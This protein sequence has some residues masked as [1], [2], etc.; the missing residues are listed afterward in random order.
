MERLYG[1]P[2]AD[3]IAMWVADMDF[4]PPNCVQRA[5]EKHGQPMVSTATTAMTRISGRDPLVDGNPPWLD[6]SDRGDLHHARSGRT[7]PRF[8]SMPLPNPVM[9]SC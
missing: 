6:G 2:A 7:A 9:A 5:I 3:G 4:R 8:A 1:V